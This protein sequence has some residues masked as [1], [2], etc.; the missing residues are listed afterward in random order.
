MATDPRPYGF[1]IHSGLGFSGGFGVRTEYGT[2]LPPAARVAAFVRSGGFDKDDPD[3]LKP[4]LLSNLDD[5]LRLC[6]SGMGDV[7]YLLPG[8]SESTTTTVLSNLKPGTHVIGLGH[9][10]LQPVIRLT[11]TAASLAIDDANCVFQNIH[12]QL[13]GANGITKAIDITAA[14]TTF[15]GCRFYF[16]SGASNHPAIAME[17]GAAADR[18]TLMGC[19]AYGAVAAA[20]TNGFLIDGACDGVR[21]IGNSIDVATTA[22]AVGPI[23]I[24]AAA[25]NILIADN[26]IR[27]N[28]ASST[29]AITLGNVAVAGRIA[30]NRLFAMGGDATPAST[31]IVLGA[32][33]KVR[34]AENYGCSE[35]DLSGVL[36]PVAT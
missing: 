11:D 9:G 32:A 34:F 31:I 20:A 18:T 28:A 17:I 33:N 8:H 21:F 3:D 27:N 4:R 1:G 14:D 24:T 19:E 7:V 22:A 23:N 2:M 29:A 35:D 15:L 26:V 10:G 36:C 12:F 13:D 5:A 16:G 6:R 30:N 25:T